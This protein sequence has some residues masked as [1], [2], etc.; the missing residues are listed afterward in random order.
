MQHAVFV[1]GTFC[2]SK[3][4]PVTD[5]GVTPRA[6]PLLTASAP[7]TMVAAGPRDSIFLCK[8]YVAHC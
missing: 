2:G 1:L 7:T 8:N 4:R 3:H 5:S 6:M